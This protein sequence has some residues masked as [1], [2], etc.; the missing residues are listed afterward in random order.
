[1]RRKRSGRRKTSL[2][3][4]E[5][6]H[7][8]KGE[9]R[10]TG[11]MREDRL[12]RFCSQRGE[13]HRWLRVNHTVPRNS[14]LQWKEM[15]SKYVLDAA[16]RYSHKSFRSLHNHKFFHTLLLLVHKP[17]IAHHVVIERHRRH[18]VS[19]CGSWKITK[20]HSEPLNC[21]EECSNYKTINPNKQK[22]NYAK[23]WGPQKD[24]F[25]LEF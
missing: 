13:T 11:W 2:G 22:M 3:R 18:T 12:T 6:S 7:N 10:V 24:S 8:N 21:S 25:H 17:L 14:R 19:I 15:I 4:D 20:P 1:M 5:F 16:A 23:G 9:Q